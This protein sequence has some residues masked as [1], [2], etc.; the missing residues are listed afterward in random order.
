MVLMLVSL[1][2][3]SLHFFSKI[4]QM[5]DCLDS[6]YIVGEFVQCGNVIYDFEKLNL[7]SLLFGISGVLL[8]VKT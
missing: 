2:T 5:A 6:L 8:L 1:S 4:P 3:L 7:T